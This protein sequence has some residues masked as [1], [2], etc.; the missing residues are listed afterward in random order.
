MLLLPSLLPN[1]NRRSSN[2]YRITEAGA[3]LITKLK[4]IL[5]SDSALVLQIIRDVS[6]NLAN[7]SSIIAQDSTGLK[8][9]IF[10]EME[11]Y[12]GYSDEPCPLPQKVETPTILRL[13]SRAIKITEKVITR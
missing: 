3:H 6:E 7:I 5:D 10:V 13:V 12:P 8:K 2:R 11:E 1:R 4:I 9:L